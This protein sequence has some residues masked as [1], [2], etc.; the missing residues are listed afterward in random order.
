M[1][2][3]TWWPLLTKFEVIFRQI[4]QKRAREGSDVANHDYAVKIN[5]FEMANSI[6]RPLL[7]K[8]EV[9]S[10]KLNKNAYG[11]QNF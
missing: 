6:G 11:S 4:S 5:N 9:F 2:D 7:T 3:S 8:F 10:F 1:A